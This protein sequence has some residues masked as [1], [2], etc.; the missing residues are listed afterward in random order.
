[1]P[2]STEDVKHVKPEAMS[3]S[4]RGVGSSCGYRS[5]ATG[6]PGQDVVFHPGTP[7]WAS[8]R[9][10]RGAAS[11]DGDAVRAAGLHCLAGR[12]GSGTVALPGKTRC[13]IG[14]VGSEAG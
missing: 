4:N 9:T 6:V 13:S 14:A 11:C 5:V 2:E 8:E 7:N 12:A 3:G 10:K 1:M